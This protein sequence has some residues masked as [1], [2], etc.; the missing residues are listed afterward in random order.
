MANG[1]WESHPEIVTQV[2]EA[3]EN[4][5]S[6][7]EAAD[8]AGVTKES[9]RSYLR[10]RRNNG[11]HAPRPQKASDG[12]RVI[13]RPGNGEVTDE[14]TINEQKIAEAQAK[15]AQKEV[16]VGYVGPVDEGFT[17]ET[18]ADT[19]GRVR[20]VDIEERGAGA[21]TDA[22][23]APESADPAF[24]S[25]ASTGARTTVERFVDGV[26]VGTTK[27]DE[28]KTFS[29]TD[30]LLAAEGI[31]PAAMVRTKTRVSQWNV[32]IK[33][34]KVD[35][36]HAVNSTYEARAEESALARFVAPD[37]R[38]L[39]YWNR[40]DTHLSRDK[41]VI[42]LVSD[43]QGVFL[44]KTNWALFLARV[45]TGRY[46]EIVLDGD[47]LNL[48]SMSGKFAFDPREEAYIQTELNFYHE[49]LRELREAL[50]PRK[51]LPLDPSILFDPL[52]TL[53]PRYDKN[54][55]RVPGNHEER[56][57]AHL[58]QKAP[59]LRELHRAGETEP[60]LSLSYLLRLDDLGVET[61]THPLYQAYEFVTYSPIPSLDITHGLLLGPRSGESVMKEVNRRGKCVA[62]GHTH[63]E[64]IFYKTLYDDRG[65]RRV[66]GLENPCMTVSGD[67]QGLGYTTHPDWQ[68]G[69]SDIVIHTETGIAVPSINNIEGNWAYHG[70]EAWSVEQ[71][72]DI[73]SVMEL[74]R[75]FALRGQPMPWE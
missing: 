2:L 54:I 64:G 22:P 9:L 46:D 44:S 73:G 66:W 60:V 39:M 72:D 74:I 53:P 28:A 61:M 4:K 24:P 69:F 21:V 30:K 67:L 57:D 68:Y 20:R 3:M 27:V 25:P 26:E 59:N 34:G 63:R 14:A 58:L 42:G 45:A 12:R 50:G 19:H 35:T 37:L 62:I 40:P 15:K 70:D 18:K 52:V 65:G 75:P 17:I 23:S 38:P 49:R 1:F 13:S 33:G 36:F 7:K 11:L 48:G 8:A 47:I 29:T 71:Q 6:L 32:Q 16:G 10:W 56:F 51:L 55:R 5:A 43:T 41:R 31:D